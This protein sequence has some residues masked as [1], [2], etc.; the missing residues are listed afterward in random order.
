[1]LALNQV[2]AFNSQLQSILPNYQF[3]HIV[4]LEIAAITQLKYITF[5]IELFISIIKLYTLYFLY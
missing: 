1:M 4:V 3:E 2:Y 5:Q